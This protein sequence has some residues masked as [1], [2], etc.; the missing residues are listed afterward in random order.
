MQERSPLD[1]AILPVQRF[2]QFRGRAPRAE[3]W[4]FYLATTIIGFLLS[5][6]DAAVGAGDVIGG[7]F[8]LLTMVPW[9]SVSV[10]R[11]HDIDRTGWW[12]ALLL[13]PLVPL[14]VYFGS[15]ASDSGADFFTGPLIFA[16]I[17]FLGAA[18]TVF[19]FSVLPGTTGSNRYG[20]DPYGPDQLEE[21]FA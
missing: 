16:L 15:G 14:V 10:R 4:W 20:P 1:W 9:I 5:L 2:A 8:S 11:L 7:L 3:Y 13:V 17:L 6:I 18:I 12:L 21:I 19:V